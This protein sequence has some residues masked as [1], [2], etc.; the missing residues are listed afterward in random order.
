MGHPPTGPAAGCDAG[1]H[2]GGRAWSSTI[3]VMGEHFGLVQKSKE[4]IQPHHQQI[5]DRP[6]T[7]CPGM[8]TPSTLYSATRSL[9]DH[10]SA[11]TISDRAYLQCGRVCRATRADDCWPPMAPIA[12]PRQPPHYMVPA[13]P[14]STSDPHAPVAPWSGTPLAGPSW[15][16]GANRR[17]R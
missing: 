10:L 2:Q 13:M 14:S 1:W 6:P 17:G 5:L 7:P 3:E 11:K 9:A 16:Y 8:H 12:R 15:A 4:T